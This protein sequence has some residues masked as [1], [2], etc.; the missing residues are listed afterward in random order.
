MIRIR[1][2]DPSDCAAIR[3]VNMAAFGRP[4]EA[5]LVD[6][7]REAARPYVSLV[8]VEG[9]RV[10]GHILFTP[11]VI[12]SEGPPYFAL[13]LAPMSVVPE[14]QGRGIGSQLLREGLKECTQ[15]GHTVVVVLGHPHYYPRFG[16]VPATA[17]GLRCEYPVP[18][19]VFMVM[20]LTPGGLQGRT[21]LIRYRP[22][23]AEV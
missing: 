22:E 19:D 20:E 15:Q 21:G 14:C 17:K 9:V 23:F 13:G 18:D 3:R 4:N 2:E 8:A 6:A 10:V 16:F 1:A 5:D 7:L 12:E 11:V